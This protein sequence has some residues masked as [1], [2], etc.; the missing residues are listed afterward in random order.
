MHA[1]PHIVWQLL[2]IRD[3]ELRERAARAAR[4]ADVR[5]A[6]P[7]EPAARRHATTATPQAAPA[8]C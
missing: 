2:E 7:A 1:Q 5:A 8:G 4:H 3:R 6:A